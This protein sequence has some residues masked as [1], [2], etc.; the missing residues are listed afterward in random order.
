MERALSSKY[1]PSRNLLDQTAA[2][3]RGEARYKLIDDQ[4]V[5]YEAVLAMVRR[6]QKDKHDKAV[7][8]VKG[9]PGTGK[10]VIAL[11]LPRHTIENGR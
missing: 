8:V 9:G 1:A 3:V 4:I 6:A 10:S 2:M 7:F 11:N 5:A